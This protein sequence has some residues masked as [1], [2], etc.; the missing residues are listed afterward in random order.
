MRKTLGACSF[1]GKKFTWVLVGSSKKG[2]CFTCVKDVKAVLEDDN[3]KESK[4]A[5]VDVVFSSSD[6]PDDIA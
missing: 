4:E 5:P 2:I 1:C 6:I 3:K